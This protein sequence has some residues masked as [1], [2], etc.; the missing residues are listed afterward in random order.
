MRV[1]RMEVSEDVLSAVQ[2]IVEHFRRSDDALID[3]WIERD[4]P[5]LEAWLVE[6]GLLSPPDIEEPA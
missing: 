2:T 1:Q 5:I 3:D 6:L 4:L